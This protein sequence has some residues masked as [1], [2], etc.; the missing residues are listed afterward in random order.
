VLTTRY[1]FQILMNRIFSGHNFEKYTNI[2]FHENPSEG[3]EFH[4]D[5]QADITIF[6]KC[7]IPVV[8]YELILCVMI[9]ISQNTT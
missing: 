7:Y 8:F 1:Y 5:G 4:A 9:I 2:K 3:A 6:F